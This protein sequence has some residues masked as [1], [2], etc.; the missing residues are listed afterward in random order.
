[1][2]RV[3]MATLGIALIAFGLF[4]GSSLE[5]VYAGLTERFSGNKSGE[6]LAGSVETEGQTAE[7]T[8]LAPEQTA[9]QSAEQSAEQALAGTQT[10]EPL[11]EQATNEDI[12]VVSAD[13]S[14][15]VSPSVEGST[16]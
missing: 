10:A 16:Q 14:G 13:Q 5:Q 11:A 7:T 4:G 6:I 12:L 3:I 8:I 9:E 1:M 15:T 2:L